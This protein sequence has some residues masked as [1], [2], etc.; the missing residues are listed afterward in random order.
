MHLH[1]THAISLFLSIV[2]FLAMGSIHLIGYETSASEA[3]LTAIT[4]IPDGTMAISGNDFRVPNGLSNI[5]AAMAL[6]NSATA[7]LRAQIQA[8]SLRS[9]LN[10]DISPIRN[11]LTNGSFARMVRMWNT[12]LALQPLEPLDVFIQNGAAVMNRAFL[13]MCDG[14]PKPVAGKIYTIRATASITLTTATWQNGILTFG[15]TLPAG[16]YQVVGMRVVGANAIAARLFFV[17]GSWRRGVPCVTVDDDNEWPDFRFGFTGVWGEF[18]NTTPPSLDVMG[19]T[20]TAQSL[21]L[22][23]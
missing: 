5:C 12:P 4:P 13:W 3:A 7:T 15:Q 16:H 10:F 6:I 18:D 21:E 22:D 23:L 9:I 2:P 20:D 19:I 17:G 14:P 8:P 1:F 11:G